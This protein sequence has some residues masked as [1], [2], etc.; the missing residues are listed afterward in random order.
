MEGRRGGGHPLLQLQV[1]FH[2]QVKVT[3]VLSS[4]QFSQASFKSQNRDAANAEGLT[5]DSSRPHDPVFISFLAAGLLFYF[6]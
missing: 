4:Q 1:Q 6:G 2:H 5:G 3:V